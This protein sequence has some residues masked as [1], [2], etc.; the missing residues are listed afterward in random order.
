LVNYLKQNAHL[1]SRPSSSWSYC[2]WIYNYLCNQC[3]S[4]LGAVLFVN[5]W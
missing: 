1:I 5:V 4:S 3:I 2:S